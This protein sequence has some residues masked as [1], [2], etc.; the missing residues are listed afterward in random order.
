MSRRVVIFGAGG[1]A[2]EV[3]WVIE[4]INRIEPRFEFLGYLVPDARH[5]GDFDSRNLILGDYAWLEHHQD[6]VDGIILAPGPAKTRLAT[7]GD[8]TRRFA[9]VHFPPILSPD[10][11]IH[12]DSSTIRDGVIISPGVTATINVTVESLAFVGIGSTISHEAR[13]GRGTYLGPGVHIG[14]GAVLGE[15]V[16]IGAGANVLPYVQ[17]GRGA[18]IGAGSVVAGD[19]GP[20]QLVGDHLPFTS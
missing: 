11:K 14:G 7:A 9:W 15:A 10:I 17:I 1:A 2:R 18:R 19:V 16:E 3:R 6:A 8:L 5:A 12:W 20:D 13:I 4:E